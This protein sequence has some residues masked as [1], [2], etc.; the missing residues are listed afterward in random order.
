MASLAEM[1]AQ[2]NQIAQ[3]NNPNFAALNT[4]IQGRTIPLNGFGDFLQKTIE[5]A[6]QRRHEASENLLNRQHTS[7]ENLLNRQH[8]SAENEQNRRHNLDLENLRNSLAKQLEADRHRNA[9]DLSERQHKNTLEIND[10]SHGNQKDLLNLQHSLDLAKK[11]Y[12]KNTKNEL[13]RLA[14]IEQ[15]RG[16]GGY[17]D[18]SNM[19]N[20]QILQ[21]NYTL[22][23]RQQQS[24]PT[25]TSA[26]DFSKVSENSSD[27]SSSTNYKQSSSLDLPPHNL[28][29]RITVDDLLQISQR[30]PYLSQTKEGRAFLNRL[31]QAI[32]NNPEDRSAL[33]PFLKEL[34]SGKI[35]LVAP[36]TKADQTPYPELKPIDEQIVSSV[37]NSMPLGEIV[38]DFVISPIING[39]DFT[40]N[41]AKNQARDLGFYLPRQQEQNYNG[42]FGGIRKAW[43]NFTQINEIKDLIDEYR[44]IYNYIQQMDMKPV[45]ISP[46]DQINNFAKKVIAQ[47]VGLPDPL[48]VQAYRDHYGKL[49]FVANGQM[50]EVDNKGNVSEVEL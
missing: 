6:R 8:L 48:Y 36:I 15:N 18:L 35:P 37:K 23:Q 45:Q 5:P 19:S 22:G 29:G 43:D 3:Q 44:P 7:S 21:S 26:P 50:F 24:N 13:Y 34:Q 16:L 12:D 28:S 32:N 4:I 31:E 40:A 14:L 39:M 17:R 42:F 20:D 2:S 38:P 1:A 9:I 49:T 11:D 27:P 30:Y 25:T 41:A 47:R 10:R 33:E 46:N